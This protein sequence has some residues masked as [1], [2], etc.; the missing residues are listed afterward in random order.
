MQHDRTSEGRIDALLA[1]MTVEE[2]LGQLQQ[3]AW[4]GDTGPGGGQN[5]LA[6]A[7]ARKGVLGSVLNLH[8]A[9][10][11]NALQRIAV[12]ESRLGVPLL[13]GFDV[14]HGFWTTFPIPLAQAAAFDPSVAVRDAEVSAAEARSNGVH[15]TF[16]PMMDV[17]HEP[18]WGRIAESGGEDPYLTAV[19]AAA[20]VR[21]Y[22]GEDLADP[23]R[24]AA[25]AKHFAG[26]GAV[27]GGRDYNTVDLSEQRL[28]NLHL[29]P[30]RAAVDAG[31]ASVMAAFTT[32][33]G[34]PA[35]AHPHLLTD[36]L[37]G[38]WGF[39]GVV[40][41]D[42]GG[43][44][45]LT[46]HGLAE[47]AADAARIA[48]GAGL[49][50]EMASTHLADHG[51][52]LL[53]RGDLGAA[54]LD[55]AVRRVLRLK[56]RLGLFER[57]Y[58]DEAAA[59]GG[60]TPES[61]AAARWAAARCTVLLK[62]DGPVLPLAATVR[63]LAVLGPFADS[64]DLHGTW[65][66]PGEARFP[67]VTVL[68]AVRAA[69]PDA[70]VRHAAG[71]AEAVAAARAAD[72][73]VLVV[74]EP[75]A[76]SGEASSR[77]DIGLPPGQ[78]ELIHAVA[79]TGTPF[80]VVLVTGRPLTVEGWID[81]APAV[82]AAWHPG[83]EA[84]H[85]IADVL[86]G[87]VNPG[88]KLPVTLPRSVGQLP[89]Y[90]N[91]ENTGRPADPDRPDAPFVSSYLDTA[92]GPRF[93]FGHGLSYTEFEIGE[94]RLAAGTASVAELRAGA[95]VEVTVAVRNT[96]PRTGD[97]VVQL[98]VHDRAASIVQPVRR[99]RGFRRVTLA[100]GESAEVRFR[101]G[102]DDLGFWTHDPAGRH[103][104]EPGAIDVY[105]GGSS[106]ARAHRTLMLTR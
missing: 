15:W 31:A 18:R 34:V 100:P 33:G 62:N 103:T 11:T 73:V 22:Q 32:V 39:D 71:G 61:R 77:A 21:G 52:E 3:L 78:E 89:L 105:A 74:G 5:H 24:V 4:N 60:P 88:G 87:S 12:E 8:G 81:A 51:R 63:S 66:G 37:K 46:V 23:R 40:V 30:F 50:M 29:P 43:V 19:L 55:D 28:R 95:H 75:T 58:A 41:S 106:A 96:G 7:A 101:L 16:S 53:D 59:L 82:L 65:S 102:A 98:Y 45:E 99:L 47:D 84:G 92:H 79:A 54:R 36:V 97:E 42:W 1:R 57:P 90:Y 85:A 68:D 70:E 104:V 25:C 56:F 13:F 48:F 10:H 2:K 38:E 35:H 72:A 6:E 9:A 49:D 69:A 94:P 17:T 27:E 67:A 14:V 91:H 64:A 93:P 44:R 26:Y 83:I 20:K 80:A 86:F 76:V